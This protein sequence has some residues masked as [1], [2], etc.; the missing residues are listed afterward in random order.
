[1]N[2]CS[3]CIHVTGVFMVLLLLLR[4]YSPNQ[5][6]FTLET[7]IQLSHIVFRKSKKKVPNYVSLHIRLSKK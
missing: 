1:M 3:A 4:K 6:E 7:L 5:M 2:V